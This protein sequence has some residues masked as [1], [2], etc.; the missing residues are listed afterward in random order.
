M[1]SMCSLTHVISSMLVKDRTVVGA[2]YK[3]EFILAMKLST[4]T[5]VGPHSVK[6]HTL[7][8]SKDVWGA[9]HEPKGR[10]VQIILVAGCP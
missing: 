8:G 10:V 7:D 4:S 3:I 9:R 1:K 2:S 5:Q 6:V